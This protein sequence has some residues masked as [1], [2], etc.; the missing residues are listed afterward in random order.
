MDVQR[1]ALTG[2]CGV[3]GEWGQQQDELHC[4]PHGCGNKAPQGGLVC[5]MSVILCFTCVVNAVKSKTSY[6]ALHTAAETKHPKV[7][8]IVYI[9]ADVLFSA[10]KRCQLAVDAVG[11]PCMRASVLC[12]NH[13]RLGVA[14]TVQHSLAS[15]P[16][17]LLLSSCR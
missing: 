1:C 4:A 12:I 8:Q 11:S 5:Y 16:L 17:Q 6:T 3:P 10:D 13:V 9:R 7:G 2:C 15:H 14:G